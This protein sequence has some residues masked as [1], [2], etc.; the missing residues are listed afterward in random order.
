MS[1]RKEKLT[2]LFGFLST[3]SYFIAKLAS[4]SLMIHVAVSL[5]TQIFPKLLT[6]ASI[7]FYDYCD[8]HAIY[9]LNL[10]NMKTGSRIQFGFLGFKLIPVLFV[11]IAGLASICTYA[12]RFFAIN[13][14]RNS[15]QFAARALCRYRL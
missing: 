11:I 3:W 10:L 15:K 1:L 12:A 9:W 4:A 8:S 6:V 13:L 5:I 2:L 14:G 7:F